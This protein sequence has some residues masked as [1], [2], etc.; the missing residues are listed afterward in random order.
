[1]G[2][3]H[4]LILARKDVP[5]EWQLGLETNRKIIR[6]AIE[7]DG[8]ISGEHGI[9]L[10]HKAIFGLEHAESIDLM[11]QIKGV[12]DPRGILNPGKIFEPK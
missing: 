3:L 5:E 11:R 4:A 7:C 1:M 6:K 12:F 8:T 9:G 2:L 10:G